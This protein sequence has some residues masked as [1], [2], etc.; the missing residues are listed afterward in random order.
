[1]NLSIFVRYIPAS[2]SKFSAMQQTLI[3]SYK[4]TY[5]KVTKGLFDTKKKKVNNHSCK[6]LL[7]FEC[8]KKERFSFSFPFVKKTWG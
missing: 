8:K 5:Y 3:K 7:F 4:K 1:M 2:K 6:V